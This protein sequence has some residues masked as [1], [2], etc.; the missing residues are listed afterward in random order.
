[1]IYVP[2]LYNLDAE[3]KA[4]DNQNFSNKI[5]PLLF[6]VMDKKTSASPKSI[7]DD[8]EALIRRKST[9]NFFVSI[10]Q[11]LPLT[12]RTLK[13]TV[14][15]FYTS[16]KTVPNSYINLMKRFSSLPNVIP[17]LDVDYSSYLPGMLTTLKTSIISSSNSYAYYVKA[18]SFHLIEKE[19]DNIIT[20]NDYLIY[21]L[22]TKDFGKSSIKKELLNI[23]NMKKRKNFNSIVIKQVYSGLTFPKYPDGKILPGTD[24]YDCIDIDFYTDFK[25]H[26]FDGFGD[27]AGIRD[28]PIYSGG[29]SYPS[30]LTVELNTFDHHGF[31]GNAKD[32]SSFE[33]IL[34]PKYLKSDH[35]NHIL[36]PAHKIVCPGCI[37][38][39]NFHLK[40]NKCND[41]KKWKTIT[42]SHFLESIDNKFQMGII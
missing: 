37:M 15:R 11:N 32:I 27:C 4:L 16:Q 20:D 14:N 6:F 3:Y 1:M 35:W 36:T 38:I 12:S 24:A 9:N 41:A 26:N 33:S 28:I 5:L 2:K 34:L 19:V 29:L 39:N 10:P 42:I 31:K 21:D 13:P 40:L 23:N 17:T 7:I 25:L 18:S 30:Y 22:D 8:F